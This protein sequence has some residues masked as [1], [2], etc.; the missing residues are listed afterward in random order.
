MSDLEIRAATVSEFAT[1][2]EWAA[3]EGW[4]PGI[5]DLAAFLSV[6]TIFETRGTQPC[7][8]SGSSVQLI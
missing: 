5:D 1:A 6:I 3:S 7:R 8:G 2:V 4:N